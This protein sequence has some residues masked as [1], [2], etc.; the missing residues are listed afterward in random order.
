MIENTER[1]G[2]VHERKI[3]KVVS[4]PLVQKGLEG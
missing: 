2:L 3:N 1:W 4:C